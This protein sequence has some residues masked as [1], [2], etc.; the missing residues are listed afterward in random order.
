MKN[1]V[2][3]NYVL[4]NPHEF[5]ECYSDKSGPFI[6]QC[7]R[8]TSEDLKF[9]AQKSYGH[10]FSVT[11]WKENGINNLLNIILFVLNK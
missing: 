1:S 3:I 10:K 4:P 5:E 8:M 2:I 7:Y 6:T 9:I 11:V